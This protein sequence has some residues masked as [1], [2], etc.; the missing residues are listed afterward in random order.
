VATFFWSHLPRCWQACQHHRDIPAWADASCLSAPHSSPSAACT[1][2]LRTTL[3]AC[4]SSASACAQTWQCKPHADAPSCL[5]TALRG[6]T[7]REGRKFGRDLARR[8][9]RWTTQW[10]DR[11]GGRTS[12]IYTPAIPS[13]FGTFDLPLPLGR[14]LGWPGSRRA[15]TANGSWRHQRHLI[16]CAT[17]RSRLD[18]GNRR[19]CKTREHCN[20]TFIT[21]SPFIP[22]CISFLAGRKNRKGRG[23]QTVC[24]SGGALPLPWA[25]MLP[26]RIPAPAPLH[27]PLPLPPLAAAGFRRHP[28]LPPTTFPTTQE[29]P[30]RA[31]LP[32]ACL[33]SATPLP[34]R[35]APYLCPTCP[36]PCTRP[37]WR[38]R[39]DAGWQR[40]GRRE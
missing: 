14:D 15:T 37:L 20:A 5:Q 18:V 23:E 4:P 31:R 19:H 40:A 27:H 28:A 22:L 10:L 16:F 21:F 3:P 13:R 7:G 30:C 12:R 36:P 11:A 25:L 33:A 29:G 35:W 8:A 9:H 2:T 38:G 24:L 34:P 26:L 1:P 17:T 39:R 6:R 32:A